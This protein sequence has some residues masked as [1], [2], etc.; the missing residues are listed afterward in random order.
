MF[1]IALP[2]WT[3]CV[4]HNWTAHGCSSDLAVVGMTNHFLIG[5]EVF[6]FS[7]QEMIHAWSFK[8]GWNSLA[9]EV[10]GPSG[11]AMTVVL[12][13]GLMLRNL[14]DLHCP[15]HYLCTVMSTI[16]PSSDTESTGPLVLDCVVSELWERNSCVSATYPLTFC[17]YY[18][19][20]LRD[21]WW[22]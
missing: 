7:P 6:F 12:L 1:A 18:L 16:W 20:R 14:R 21:D 15:S 10:I 11:K 13:N 19:S 4:I 9:W 2:R 3:C 8:P 22:H 5:F 17:C